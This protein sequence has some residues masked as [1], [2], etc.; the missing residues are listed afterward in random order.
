LFKTCDAVKGLTTCIELGI[1]GAAQPTRADALAW[2]AGR[3]KIV[4]LDGVHGWGYEL[5]P[6]E[7]VSP[8]LDGTCMIL[9]ALTPIPSV[10]LPAV[11][12]NAAWLS[13]VQDESGVW[14][15]AGTVDTFR[16]AAALIEYYRATK[17]SLADTNTEARA[18]GA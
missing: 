16:I 14:L 3:E 12:A 17:A 2:I 18:A 8:Q 4:Q 13:R 5:Q 9:E 11:A 1:G 6:D 10:P 15:S 7:S